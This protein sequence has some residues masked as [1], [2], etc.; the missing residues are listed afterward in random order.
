MDPRGARAVER[1][2]LALAAPMGVW[3]L[4]LHLRMVVSSAPQEMR[5]GAVVWI[6]RLLLEGRNPYA[7]EELPAGTNVYGILYHLI[8]L[9]FA[10]LSGN[11]YAVHRVVSAAAIFGACLLFYRLLRRESVDQSIALVGVLLFYASSLY[12]VAP[13]ARPDGLGVFLSMASVSLL[14]SGR[15]TS[16]RF[17]AGLALALL[18]FLTKMYLAYPPFVLAAYELVF[19]SKKRGVLYGFGSAMACMALLLLLSRVYPAYINV[20]IVANTQEMSYDWAHAVGQTLDWLVFSL[21]LAVTFAITALRRLSA[22]P[23]VGPPVFAFV[24]GANLLVFA[25]W[26]GG[27]PGAHMTYLFQLVTPA[28]LLALLPH[29][30]PSGWPRALVTAALPVAFVWNAHYFPLTFG[31]FT[32]AE[33][34]FARMEDVVRSSRN[35]LGSTEVAGLLALEGRRVFDSGQSQY[36]RYASVERAL[37]GL[38]PAAAIASR[39]G[40]FQAE[41]A[42]GIESQTFDLIVRNRRTGVIPA[43][44]VAASYRREDSLDVDLPWSGQQWPLDLWRPAPGARTGSAADR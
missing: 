28:L 33:R 11:S 40:A 12:F 32:A 6:T 13:L 16:Q 2:A 4:L 29:V 23:P 10:W 18:A 38:V 24:G 25:I 39:W 43:G 20:S 30:G 34:T 19:G 5:E 27:H 26:L 37:P 31:R 41:I 1:G 9:P 44:L 7:L 21:P 22:P 42:G 8:V 15:V 3:L 36:F 35:V 17:A 14:F